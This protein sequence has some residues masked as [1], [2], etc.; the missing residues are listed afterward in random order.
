MGNS[1]DK[2][3]S[4]SEILFDCDED[5]SADEKDSRIKELE[6]ELESYRARIAS[7]NLINTDY[8]MED[9]SGET[10]DGRKVECYAIFRVIPHIQKYDTWLTKQ[11]AVDR[12][13]ELGEYTG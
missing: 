1:K 6:E 12:L 7:G 2:Y 13:R 3:F 11:Q 5:D 9:L 4:E 10:A 8:Y